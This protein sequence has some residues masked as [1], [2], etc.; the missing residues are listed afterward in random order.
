MHGDRILCRLTSAY[1]CVWKR[2]RERWKTRSSHLGSDVRREEELLEFKVGKKKIPLD[3]FLFFVLFSLCQ[4]VSR[5]ERVWRASSKN[6]VPVKVTFLQVCFSPTTSTQQQVHHVLK[7]L[8][9]S[10]SRYAGEKEPDL[11]GY[12]ALRHEMHL[13]VRSIY[14]EILT[15]SNGLEIS[16][17]TTSNFKSC[18]ILS[19]IHRRNVYHLKTGDNK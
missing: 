16:I 4:G 19:V 7:I 17:F 15:G 8:R 1:A 18:I 9:D 3:S 5:I 12:E 13:T 14:G 11:G 10:F 6:F 2:E